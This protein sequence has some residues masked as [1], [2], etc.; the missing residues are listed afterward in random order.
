MK[1]SNVIET[2]RLFLR[3][4][5]EED[6]EVF[7][8]LNLDEEV[9]RFTGDVPF[10]TVEASRQFILAYSEYDK[11]GYGRFSVVTKSS[12]QV[13]GWCGL[14]YHPDEDYTDLGY[15]ILRQYWG[16]GYAT[17]ASVACVSYGFKTLGLDEIIGR[18]AQENT[19]S[20][21]V[22]EKIGMRFWKKAPCEGIENS[23]FYRINREEWGR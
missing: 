22:L 14:K 23:V 1:V 11:H 4:F 15:R 18:T 16:R 8:L 21:R 9:M 10:D 3:P 17:E 5:A 7:Y 2:P 12:S 13:I 6:A 19:A 20:V